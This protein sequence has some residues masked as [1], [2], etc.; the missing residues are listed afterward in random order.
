MIGEEV[1]FASLSL[2]N[3][4]AEKLGYKTLQVKNV[5]SLQMYPRASDTLLDWLL[6][7][8]LTIIVLVFLFVYCF[9]DLEKTGR[10]FNIKS[11]SDL[12]REMDR[13]FISLKARFT[14][15]IG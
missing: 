9:N 12:Y 11:M 1:A 3:K 14:N 2:S 6:I 8:T 7:F 10:R 5:R 15:V 13:L 4:E